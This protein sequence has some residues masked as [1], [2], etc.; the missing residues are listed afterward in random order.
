[1]NPEFYRL[2]IA[3]FGLLALLAVVF[4]SSQHMTATSSAWAKGGAVALAVAGLF[5]LLLA[6]GRIV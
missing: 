4:F 1:M 3:L 6:L 2:L 5:A